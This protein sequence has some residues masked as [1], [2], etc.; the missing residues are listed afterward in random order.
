MRAFAAL[1]IG[2]EMKAK[3]QMMSPLELMQ[4]L[5]ALVP[6]PSLH[7]IRFHGV[8]TPNAKLRRQMIPQGSHKDEEAPGVAASGVQCEVETAQ[9]RP[10]HINWARL[11]KRVFDID[12]Q[13]C[14]NCG[15]AE[16]KIIA[17]ILQLPCVHKQRL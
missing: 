8:L 12:I 1:G 7:P 4:R 15:A 6:R 3:N 2:E 9:A 14:P 5:A 17:A 11:F 16:P 13:R 10:E